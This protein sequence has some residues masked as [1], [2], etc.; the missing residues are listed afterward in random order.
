[1][2]VK[3][4]FDWAGKEFQKEMKLMRVKGEEYT[5]S[6]EDKL[7]N[8]KSIAERLDT[9]SSQVAMVYLLKHMDSIRN[10]VLKGVEVSDESISGRIHDARNY[11]LLLHAIILEEKLK[12]LAVNRKNDSSWFGRTEENYSASSPLKFKT[13]TMSEA[14]DVDCEKTTADEYNKE[15]LDETSCNYR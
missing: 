2:T 6:D 13:V 15:W 5:V 11:L 1:M 9:T 3:D 4:F 14:A 8:F 10:Y 7:K 12:G